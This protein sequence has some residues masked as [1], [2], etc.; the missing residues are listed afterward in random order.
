ML[1]GLQV[2]YSN[3]LKS[4]RIV[5]TNHTVWSIKL[6]PNRYI[7]ILKES[8]Q[9]IAVT[10][11]KLATTRTSYGQPTNTKRTRLDPTRELSFN[12]FLLAERIWTLESFQFTPKS[13][14]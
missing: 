2:P 6:W 3:Y 7:G 10:S 12:V 8:F 14:Q 9:L 1:F 13:L 4:L 11:A 5:G